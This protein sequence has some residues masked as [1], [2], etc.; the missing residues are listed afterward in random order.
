[1]SAVNILCLRHTHCL[2]RQ[3]DELL[4]GFNAHIEQLYL[5]HRVCNIAALTL[6]VIS[7]TEVVFEMLVHKSKQSVNARWRW[8]GGLEGVK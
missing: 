5:K 1:M 7:Y 4:T 8:I 6:S 3:Q 2:V